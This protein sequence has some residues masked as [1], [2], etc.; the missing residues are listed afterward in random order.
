MT[1]D[2][3]KELNKT[4]EEG[5]RRWVEIEAAAQKVEGMVGFYEDNDINDLATLLILLVDYFRPLNSMKDQK[6]DLDAMVKKLL[7]R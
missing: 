1:Q 2:P 6:I 7:K 5:K 3:F 4:I